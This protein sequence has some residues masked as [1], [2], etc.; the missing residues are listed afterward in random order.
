MGVVCQCLV[1]RET[2]I[3]T[4]YQPFHYGDK[5]WKALVKER[6]ANDPSLKDEVK[7]SASDSDDMV[8]GIND[9][10]TSGYR[11]IGEDAE[12]MKKFN[13]RKQEIFYSEVDVVRE[14]QF[15]QLQSTSS[16]T[17]LIFI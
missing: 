4:F 2:D 9:P 6:M 5:H 17:V 7:A 10:Y 16:P 1:G 15:E 8:E 11:A 14:I 12:E 13:W 3:L